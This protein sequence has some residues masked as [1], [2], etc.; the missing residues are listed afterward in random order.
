MLHNVDLFIDVTL[1]IMKISRKHDNGLRMFHIR[2]VSTI[3]T[4]VTN[5]QTHNDEILFYSC[6]TSS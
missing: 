5:Q 4:Y 1:T 3:N 2:A 6:T